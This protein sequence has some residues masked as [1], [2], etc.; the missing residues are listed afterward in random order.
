MQ[1]YGLLG[2]RPTWP[3][4]QNQPEGRRLAASPQ[5]QRWYGETGGRRLAASLSPHL[6]KEQGSP[7]EGGPQH[8]TPTNTRPRPRPMMLRW[9]AASCVPD[10]AAAM[11]HHRPP[12]ASR[13][14]TC[15]ASWGDKGEGSL[16][17]DTSLSTL[18]VLTRHWQLRLMFWRRS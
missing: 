16:H 6:I 7:C 15:Q 4:S 11:G 9:N 3:R 14:Y 2:P 1:L 8:W 13:T 12:A 17:L 5:P 10:C 18:I